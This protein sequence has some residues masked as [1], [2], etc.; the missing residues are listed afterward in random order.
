MISTTIKQF[1]TAGPCVPSKHYMLPVLP[2]IQGIDEMFDGEYYFIIHAPRQSGKTTYLNTLTDRICAE[3][4]FYGLCCSLETCNMVTDDALAMTRIIAEI[5][6]ALKISGISNLSALS[7]PDDSLPQADPSIIVRNFL[8]YL[9]VNLDK[10]L[11]IFF[12]EADC[13]TETPL[14]T[15]LR[16]IRN[17]Y[18]SRNRSKDAKFPRSMALVG[19][20]DIR[21]YLVQTRSGILTTGLASPF[22]VKKEALTLANFTREEIGLLFQQHTIASRQVF[23][24]EAV[25]RAWYWSQGQPWLVNALAYEIVVKILKNNYVA[26][27]TNDLMDQAAEALINNRQTHIDSL[28]ERLKEPRVISVMDSVFSG[29]K[30]KVSINSDERQYC[31]DLGLVVLRE[32]YNLQ[33][34]NRIYQEVM[35]RVLTDPV[36]YALD[37]SIASNKYFDGSLI[38][39]SDL[40]KDFQQHWRQNVYSFPKRNKMLDAFKYDEAVHIMMLFP[41]V[42]KALNG[43]AKVYR[44]YLEGR[45]YVDICATYKDKQYLIEVKIKDNFKITEALEQIA[46]YLDT[47]GENEAW[48]VVFDRNRNK[49]WDDKI[50]WE[51]VQVNKFTIHIV[52]C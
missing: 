6:T 36:Q 46:T 11:V 12:D 49:S 7:Y 3:T 2:R 23:E 22:N 33:P 45:G 44:E 21:D 13:L 41:Y 37:D 39:M 31:I 20:R 38:R 43:A 16:Q 27:I 34:A 4:N 5:N 15:F 25:E 47:S 48:L 8:N 29:A 26:P 42:Q 14:I 1:N 51:T 18:N 28:L 19:M 35:S 50:T 9:C 17:G 10:D 24:S 30:S 40:L 32:G 52:G